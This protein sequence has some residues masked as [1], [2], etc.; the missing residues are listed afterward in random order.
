MKRDKE[1]PG[2]QHMSL[3]ICRAIADAGSISLN[4]PP[5]LI[6]HLVIF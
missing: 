4:L 3:W 1:P 6:P 5:P 2:H